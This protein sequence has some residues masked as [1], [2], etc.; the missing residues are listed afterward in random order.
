MKKIFISLLLAA[1]MF[2]AHAQ[3]WLTTGNTLGTTGIFGSTDNKNIKFISHNKNRGILNNEGLWGFGTTSPVAQVHINSGDSTINVLQV[4]AFDSPKMIVSSNGGVAIGNTNI[5]PA[6]G[7]YVSGKLGIG[8]NTPDVKLHVVGG[9]EVTLAGGGTIVSGQITG[10][11]LAIDNNDIQTR[12]NGSA[13]ML[14]INAGGGD[15]NIGNGGLYFRSSPMRSVG[16][17]TTFPNSSLQVATGAHLSKISDLG[18]FLLGSL[19]GNNIVMADNQ[20]QARNNGSGTGTLYLNPFG[21]DVNIAKPN[22]T[23]GLVVG[24]TASKNV[25]INSTTIEGRD[26][27]IF[28]FLHLNPHGAETIVGGGLQVD[29]LTITLGNTQ[30]TNDGNQNIITG[31]NWV[32]DIDNVWQLG[33][34]SNRW[35]GIWAVDGSINTSDARDKKNIRDLNYGLKEIMQLHPIKFNWKDGNNPDDKLGL[36]AQELQKVLPEVVKDHAYKKD[37]T[38]RIEKVAATRLGVMYSDIIPVLIKAMQEQQKEIDE[39]KSIIKQSSRSTEVNNQNINAT[40]IMLSNASLEQN[41]PNPFNNTTS[42]RYSIPANAKNAQIII[43]D[44]NGKIVKQISL[45]KTGSGILNINASLLN[46]GVYNYTL[47]ANHKAV[48]T[49]KMV[50]AK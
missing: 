10:N 35:L 28:S 29:G 27:G 18:Y 3:N 11:N 26:N 46:A 43:N 30:I 49:K 22:G 31:L 19:D 40:A 15:V 12:N 44:M 36:I 39:L 50:V 41:I 4:D 8:T 38:G 7:L 9:N 16:I 20:I 13:N 32:P 47:F 42:I 48:V 25:L 14:Y 17:G 2:T 34:P 24:S 33:S 6:N 37:S 5:P 1:N 23:G 45:D 21:G